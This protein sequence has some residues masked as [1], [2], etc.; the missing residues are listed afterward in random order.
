[1]PRHEIEAAYWSTPA[2]AFEYYGHANCILP[3]EAW[4]YFAF[5]R[6]ANVDGTHPWF[7]VHESE[8]EEVRARLREG[9]VTASDLGGARQGNGG[10]WSWSA[11]KRAVELLY[12]RG[13]AVC[14]ERRGWKRFYDLPERAIPP[15]LLSHEPTDA[16][17]I[18]YL[19]GVT[20]RALGVGTRRDIIEYLRLTR[21]TQGSRLQGVMIDEAIEEQG[22]VAVEVEGWDEVAYAPKEALAEPVKGESRTT[23][24]SPFDSLIWDR[25]IARRTER[26]FGFTYLLEAYVPKDERV[27]GYFVMPS[28]PV[29]GWLVGSILREKARRWWHGAF[30][31]TTRK[32]PQPWLLPCARSRDGSAAIASR[33]RRESPRHCERS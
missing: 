29:A 31:W 14:T 21:G 28:S 22:L 5:K 27:H 18:S 11:A 20:A 1:V 2:V 16:E 24:L 7:T 12:Y 9:P 33:S 6:R 3:I 17:C 26:L 10:W 23:L 32:L 13:E 8:V 30:R 19:V 25:K 15:E 4:P